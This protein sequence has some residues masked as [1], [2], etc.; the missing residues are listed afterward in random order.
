[1][2][3]ERE[4]QLLDFVFKYQKTKFYTPSFDEMAENIGC[5]QATITKTVKKLERRGLVSRIDGSYKSLRI[6]KTPEEI[7]NDQE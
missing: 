6:I 3:N 7:Y 2:L 1:M 5:C 4:K